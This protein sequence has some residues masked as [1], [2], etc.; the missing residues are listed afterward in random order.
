MGLEVYLHNLESQ[1][2]G[3][4]TWMYLWLFSDIRHCQLPV[5]A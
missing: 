4:H 2:A 5:T 3:L 1:S